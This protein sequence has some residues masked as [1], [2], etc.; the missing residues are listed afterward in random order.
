MSKTL[1]RIENLHAQY[2]DKNDSSE[3][4]PILKGIDLEVQ[5]GEIHAIMG[6]NGSGKST[7]SAT[8][9]GHPSYEIT[10]GKILLAN[11]QGELED[12][13][14]M[15]VHERAC[16]GLFLSFQYPASIPGLPVAQFL[17]SSLRALRD[18]D[19]PAREFRQELHQNMDELKMKRE[20]AKRYLNDGFSGGEKKRMEILQMSLIKPRLAILDEIDSG[21]DIDAL[22][23]V[24]EG[25]VR[26]VQP[27]RSFLLITHYKRLLDYV[28][29]HKIHILA[30]GKIIKQ[31][32]QELAERLEEEGYDEI[33][34]EAQL[35]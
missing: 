32:S 8:I 2:I 26:L 23:L 35:V 17:R 15:P 12:I 22:R 6:P 14:S 11:R 4:I 33:L 20:F 34:R 5:E 10:Q 9:M 29:P 13:T 28:K 25:I 18:S 21:L 1:L 24:A 27:E 16:K 31:G 30:Q 3:K 19:I 7:L